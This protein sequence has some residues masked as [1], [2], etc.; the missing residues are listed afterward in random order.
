M[1]DAGAT[2]SKEHA[3]EAPSTDSAAPEDA[4][5]GLPALGPRPPKKKAAQPAE[6]AKEAE[7]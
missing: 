6:A 1:E 5:K 2:A 7:S 3:E 4:V